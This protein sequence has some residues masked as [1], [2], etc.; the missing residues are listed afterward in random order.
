MTAVRDA[1]IAPPV[2]Q[3]YVARR[4]SI[5]F[6]PIIFI[7][8]YLAFTFVLTLVG[9]VVYANFD[10]VRVGL[11]LSAVGIAMLIGY[12]FAVRKSMAMAMS[13]TPVINRGWEQTF[14]DTVLAIS[15]LGFA[16]T[17][18]NFITSGANLDIGSVGEAYSEL[19]ERERGAVSQGYSASFIL[20]SILAAPTFL[21]NILGIYY[22]RNLSLARKLAVVAVVFGVPIIFMLSAGQQKTIGDLI[23][24]LGAILVIKAS[25]HRK[26]L[27]ARTIILLCGVGL[28]GLYVFSFILSNR[29]AAI[30]IGAHNINYRESDLLF[31][32]TAHPLF[33]IFGPDQGFALSAFVMYLTNGL[34]GLS[35]ALH[36]DPT[37]SHFY[38]SSYSISVIA[39]R[40]LGLPPVIDLTYP[41]VTAYESGWGTT[42]WYSVFAWFA[43][44]FTWF[45][46]IPLFGWLSYVYGRCWAEIVEFRNPFA[47]LLF[48]LLSLGVV[49][50]P[51]NNQL[52]QSPGG[53]ATLGVTVVLYLTFRRRYN[54]PELAV[55]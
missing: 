7:I 41:S 15:L 11:Y 32:D 10:A 29:Y 6:W 4:D 31:Y 33:Q 45:G 20:Y 55:R 38:G 22:F 50:I 18:F 12:N 48:C 14:F 47:M 52:M 36:T 24:Y 21:I 17:L 16:Y 25:I 9:P 54:R 30:G 27:S 1:W 34:N 26:P 23:V 2:Q 51:A 40:Y 5:L 3:G 39:E 28:V 49:M 43:S 44:D 35:Y 37:W 53:L 46:T 8:G 13:N 19:Y 42:R